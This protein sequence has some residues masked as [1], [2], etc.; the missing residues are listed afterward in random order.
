MTRID[1]SRVIRSPRGTELSAKSWLTEAALRMLMNNLDPDVAEKPGELVVYGGIGR[2][3]RTWEDFDRIV[4]SLRSLEADETLLVQSGKPV[5]IFR[6]HADAPRVL[7]ANSNLVPA[8]ANWEHFHELDKAGLMMY[9][10]MTAGSWIYIGTQ[11]IVQGTYETFVEIGRQHY[12]GS[13]K[14]KWILT[15]GLGGMGGAQP[16]AATMAGASMIAVECK[17]SSIE[18]R[19]RT[20]YLDEKAGSVDEALKII[21]A[22]HAR[23]KAVSVGVL[24]NAA[25]VFPDMVRRGIRPDVVTDQTSA[26]DPLNGYLPAGW[27]LEEWEE[28]K[29]RDPAGTIEAAKQS[30]AVHVRAMLDFQRMGVPTLDYGNNIR[31]MA[32]DMGVDNA[33]D[34]PG[35]VPAYIR[36]LF[37]RGVGPFR[38]AA[39]SGD[40]EDIYRT[41]QRVKELM[42]DDKHLHNWLDMARERIKFQGLPARICW[43]GLGDRH[44]LGL[45]FNEMVAKGEVKAPIVIGRDHLDSGSVASPNRETE[46]M[47]DG[48]DAVSDWPLLNALLNTAGG[49]TWVSLHHGGGVGMGYS[50]HAGVVIVADGTP[51]AAKRLERVLWNDPATGVM[52]HADAGYEIAI[53]C[54]KAKGLKL[55]GILG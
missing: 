36:P 1:N 53:D 33:F 5:G 12:N 55:P 9:G 42:P 34:F 13:L 24:G 8:Y 18:F 51:E 2:A 48:S 45:A 41:D 31:Q 27:T 19:L 4:A 25:E 14:G 40:P 20:G 29:E 17:P 16:L 21:E 46:A 32:K 35:F 54:A 3:A 39:L 6:T 11:G 23:G 30:M 10:Q 37:C 47:K 43:V 38:W 52:R 44:R 22:A 50:Q 28:R 15:G 49:A 26:H 7:I